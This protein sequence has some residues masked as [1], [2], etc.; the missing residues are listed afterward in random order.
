M[1]TNVDAGSTADVDVYL[2]PSLA[3]VRVRVRAPDPDPDPGLPPD[4]PLRAA[5]APVRV[6]VQLTVYARARVHGNEK[7]TM[8]TLALVARPADAIGTDVSVSVPVSVF[9]SVL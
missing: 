7:G 9:L 2:V 4:H 8:D 6:H 1:T 3:L 5:H